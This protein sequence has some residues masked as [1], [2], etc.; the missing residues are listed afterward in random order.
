MADAGPPLKQARLDTQGPM[1]TTGHKQ[2]LQRLLAEGRF[3]HPLDDEQP[4]FADLAHA[5]A[6]L[7]VW[8]LKGTIASRRFEWLCQY[9]DDRFRI[10][11]KK[12]KNH[13]HGRH[14]GESA[15]IFQNASRPR[16]SNPGPRD[17]LDLAPLV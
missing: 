8:G 17:N 10:S 13:G 2:K 1:G 7:G 6:R 15:I 11:A 16:E 12:P 14:L 9:Y 3:V 4:S 5:L